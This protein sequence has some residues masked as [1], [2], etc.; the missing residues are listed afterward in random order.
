MADPRRG[1]PPL[2]VVE[3]ARN[4]GKA[5]SSERGRTGVPFAAHDLDWSILMARAQNG[6]ADAYRCLLGE[7]TPY[8]RSLAA[9]QHRDPGDVED[10][11]QD[12]LLT[13][14]AVRQT[15]DPTRPFGPWLLTIANRRLVD[16][17]RRL[18]RLKSR[19]AAFTA[20]HETFPAARANMDTEISA[21]RELAAAL[22]GLPVGQRRAI[23]L[24]KLEELSLK[25]AAAASG[26]SVAA[27]KAATHRALRNLRKKLSIGATT[28]DHDA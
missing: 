6:D 7:I 28:R 9:R 27:L 11:V 26:M 2:T 21:R 14:H 24:L 13:V 5:S 1:V 4:S 12:V 18:Q 3:G 10:A 8:V 19:E 15:Y 23:R 25:E 22:E 20:E 17:L 16:R